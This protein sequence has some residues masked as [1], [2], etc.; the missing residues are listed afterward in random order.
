MMRR[1]Q[2][3][4]AIG[5]ERALEEE[6]KRAYA[7]MVRACRTAAGHGRSVAIRLANRA[8]A[9][10]SGSYVRAFAVDVKPDGAVLKNTSPHA[11]FVELGRRPGRMPPIGVILRWMIDKGLI[12]RI[13]IPRRGST[14]G[15]LP[16][17][18]VGRGNRTRIRALKREHVAQH[19]LTVR[20]QFIQAAYK[21]AWAIARKI[22][23]RGIKGKRIM[24]QTAGELGRFLEGEI[25]RVTRG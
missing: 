17:G 11:G 23:L 13:P 7:A 10:A 5:L 19:R 12:G 16:V 2:V 3:S 25:R 20:Q 22:A 8:G 1:V 24:E 15:V 9:R 14:G 21:R 6:E 4:G 18:E